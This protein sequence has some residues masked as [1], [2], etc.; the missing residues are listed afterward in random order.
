MAQFTVSG[1]TTI[2]GSATL[3]SLSIYAAAN[4]RPRIVEVNLWNTT[5]T[6]VTVALARLTTA[7]TKGAAITAFDSD[8]LP[9]NPA[10]ATVFAGHTV[11]PTI[12]NEK[13]RTTLAAAVGSGVMWT[14]PDGNS[15]HIPASATNGIGVYIPTGTGQVLDYSLTWV[16]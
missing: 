8:D 2:A 13:K 15:L 10:I 16:E 4:C 7:G 11:G 14:W 12:T 3:P 5:S 9:E 1:R 6:A